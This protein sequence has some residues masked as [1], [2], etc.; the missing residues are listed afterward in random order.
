MERAKRPKSL[1]RHYS[2]GMCP[3]ALLQSHFEWKVITRRLFECDKMHEFKHA[4]ILHQTNQND[5]HFA[6]MYGKY[7]I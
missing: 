7:K 5:L 1:L 2:E 3:W 4:P 6:N